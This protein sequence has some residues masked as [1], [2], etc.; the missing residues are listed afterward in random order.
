MFD[1]RRARLG[2]GALSLALTSVVAL[3]ATHPSRV[4]AGRVVAQASP[5]TA[6]SGGNTPLSLPPPPAPTGRSPLNP[7]QPTPYPLNTLAPLTPSTSLPFPAYGTPVPGVNRGV[8]LPGVPVEISLQQAEMVGFAESPTLA[9][10]RADVGVQ[11][12][13]VRL[14]RAGLLPNVAGGAAYTYNHTQP[15]GGRSSVTSPT[16]GTTGTGTTLIPSNVTSTTDASVDLT[17]SQ[18][19]F[20]GGKVAASV[21][22]AVRGETNAADTYR[23]DLQTVAFN[24]ATA[25]YNYLAAERT[26]QVD[27]EIVRED[28]VQVDLVVAQVKAGTEARAEI[29]TV[30]LPLAQARLAV[31][32]AQGAEL[33]AAAAFDNSMGLDANGLVQPIDDA[34]VFTSNP[35][36]TV[37]VPGYDQ[38]LKRAYALR[39]DYYA[40]VDTVQQAQYSLKSAKLAYFPTLSANGTAADSSTGTSA[41]AFRN[42][43]QVGL[44]LSIPIYAQGTIEANI[45]SAK[46]TLNS[47][48][49]SLQNTA[50]TVQL[51]VKQ[52]LTSLVSAAQALT[53]TQQEYKTA[54]V[55]LE[56]TQAQ[57]RA[58]V[59]TLPLLLNAQVQLTQ[60]LTDQVTAVYTLRQA[61][62]TYLFQIGANFDTSQDNGG[63]RIRP[64]PGPGAQGGKTASRGAKQGASSRSATAAAQH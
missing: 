59:T 1:F 19:I 46:A 49:A 57:Y 28:Q 50:L 30:E 43:Q 7:G 45:A 61:E 60:A 21:D 37:P 3:S 35:V 6:P 25:Y 12:A 39:P 63:L 56:S 47:A 24:V 15:G 51:S 34:P 41:N 2:L 13:A 22:A 55:N 53:E 52:A 18:L 29:A 26:T 31:V 4:E 33:S 36:S 62:Q 14:A 42:S 20:D 54:V 27:L 16:V 64:T 48:Y 38:A 10:A 9:V 11:A 5:A 8:A 40:A 32:K 44:Q 17:I 23:R 58:G